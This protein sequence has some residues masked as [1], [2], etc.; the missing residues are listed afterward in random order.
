M[1]TSQRNNDIGSKAAKVTTIK[2]SPSKAGTPKSG[3]GKDSATGKK[4]GKY[5]Q[6]YKGHVG[7][8]RFGTR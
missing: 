3:F 6:S 8:D 1:K 5:S 7:M 2:G 4:E